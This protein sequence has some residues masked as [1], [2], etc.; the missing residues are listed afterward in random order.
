MFYLTLHD[1]H[2]QSS[3]RQPSTQ[4]ELPTIFFK[5]LVL[6]SLQIL[7][8]DVPGSDFYRN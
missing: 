6:R 5:S 3:C 8:A 1:L 2:V 7:L 4:K